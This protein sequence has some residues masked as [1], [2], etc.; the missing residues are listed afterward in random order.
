MSE[1]N[2]IEAIWSD[3]PC[4]PLAEVTLEVEGDNVYRI[5]WVDI[6][7]GDGDKHFLMIPIDEAEKLVE[8]LR[9]AIKEARK[10]VR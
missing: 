8:K 2:R 4:C 10:P 9:E 5:V 3:V 6:V 1:K 7:F